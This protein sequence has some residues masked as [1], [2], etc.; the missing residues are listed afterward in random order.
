MYK[1][2]TTFSTFPYPV[3]FQPGAILAGKISWYEKATSS[4]KAVMA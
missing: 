3:F 1:T 2:N 4:D